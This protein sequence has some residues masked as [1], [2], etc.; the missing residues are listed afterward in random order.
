MMSS[1][2]STVH[3]MSWIGCAT[4]IGIL[5]FVQFNNATDG[6]YLADCELQLLET[7]SPVVIDIFNLWKSEF[8]GH[9]SLQTLHRC[10]IL[11][12]MFDQEERCQQHL[13][14]KY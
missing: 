4:V 8:V 13:V 9:I 10:L 1:T 7:T 12:C 3:T 5:S 14:V 2:L 11:R 6:M